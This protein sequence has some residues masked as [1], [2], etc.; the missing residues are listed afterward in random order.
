MK[1]NII[2][3]LTALAMALS[4][5]NSFAEEESS[6]PE[7]TPTYTMTFLDFEGEVM[8]TIEVKAGEKIDYTQIDTS[9]LHSHIDLYTEQAFS[10]WSATPEYIDSDT[11]VQA[12]YKKAAISVEGTPRKTEYYSA[13]GD[14]N[15]DGLS[16]LI[17]LEIQTPVTDENGNYYVNTQ[18]ENIINSCYTEKNLEELFKEEK[19]ATVNVIPAGDDKP[20]FTY[21]ITLFDKLGDTNEDGIVDAVDASFVL[22]TYAKLSTGGELDLDEDKQKICD[23]NQDGRIDAQDSTFILMYYAEASTSGNPV[24]EEI[25]PSLA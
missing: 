22:L 1:K 5:L 4:P 8:Q 6:P 11:T 10:M 17:T 13:L 21:D 18:T 24:W 16:V 7:D 12:L 20:I 14:I 15:L 9:S 19:Q 2:L 3:S 25:V 23:I